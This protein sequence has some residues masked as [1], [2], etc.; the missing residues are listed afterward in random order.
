[1]NVAG[2]SPYPLPQQ[3]TIQ[4][5]PVQFG[6]CPFCVVLVGA[7]ATGGGLA[8]WIASNFGNQKPQ[9]ASSEVQKLD[10]EA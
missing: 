5:K 7:A 10:T 6:F 8:G 3:R 9:P 1:M 4:A 2:F